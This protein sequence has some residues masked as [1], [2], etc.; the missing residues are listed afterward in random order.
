MAMW[1][2]PFQKQNSLDLPAKIASFLPENVSRPEPAVEF[3]DY[4]K[5][6]ERIEEII[7]GLRLNAISK[8]DLNV[9]QD[10]S[11]LALKT[12]LKAQIKV[13]GYINDSSLN[14]A[15]PWDKRTGFP[16]HP[17]MVADA[18]RYVD[19]FKPPEEV[20]AFL[21]SFLGWSQVARE[22]MRCCCGQGKKARTVI[23]FIQLNHIVSV[24]N[25][26]YLCLKQFVGVGSLDSAHLKHHYDFGK[27]SQVADDLH[28][29]SVSEQGFRLVGKHIVTLNLNPGFQRADQLNLEEFFRRVKAVE[30]MV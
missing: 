9:Y 18:Q 7:T 6:I 1:Q 26:E 19:F 15:V 3:L 22:E 28:I 30:E 17:T 14:C 24:V 5:T 23:L 12:L 13:L 4:Q 21:D 8:I 10:L 2:M 20:K 16:S 25:D 11:L 27:P 29:I